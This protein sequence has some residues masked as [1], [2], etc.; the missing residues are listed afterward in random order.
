MGKFG[1][2]ILLICLIIIAPP[3]WGCK[4]FVQREVIEVAG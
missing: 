1:A 4:P 2:D 3:A